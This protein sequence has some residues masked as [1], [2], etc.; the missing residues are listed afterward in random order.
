M[1]NEKEPQ[2]FCN[3]TVGRAA[4]TM[5]TSLR[6]GI[7]C[8]VFGIWLFGYIRRDLQVRDQ[9]KWIR[10]SAQSD[11]ACVRWRLSSLEQKLT[12]GPT[13]GVC[14]KLIN[15]K[16][17]KFERERASDVAPGRNIHFGAIVAAARVQ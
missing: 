10:G 9:M 11:G 7:D 15:S 3:L 5:E 6:I 12:R 14:A 17:V 2:N 16:Y 4:K 8:W 13:D 1:Y